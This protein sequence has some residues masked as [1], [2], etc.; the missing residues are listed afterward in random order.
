[1]PKLKDLQGL[2]FGRLVVVSR[3]YKKRTTKIT[4]K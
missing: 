1:M 4:R 3:D 2:R